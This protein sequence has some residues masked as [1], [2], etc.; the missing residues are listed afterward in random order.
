MAT[1]AEDM[2]GTEGGAEEASGSGT[3]TDF[4]TVQEVDQSDVPHHPGADPTGPDPHEGDLGTE[5]AG[6]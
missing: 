4:P 2:E 1:E 3:A 6:S 5:E